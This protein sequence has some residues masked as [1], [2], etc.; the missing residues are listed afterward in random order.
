MPR[1]AVAPTL[2]TILSQLWDQVTDRSPRAYT[3][4]LYHKLRGEGLLLRDF[5]K[6]Q[7]DALKKLIPLRRRRASIWK[8]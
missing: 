1:A 6:K 5:L 7:L 2:Q 4:H 3:V 8:S